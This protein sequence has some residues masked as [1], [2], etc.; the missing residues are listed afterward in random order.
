MIILFWKAGLLEQGFVPNRQTKKALE[1]HCTAHNYNRFC[2]NIAGLYWEHSKDL[3]CEKTVNTKRVTVSFTTLDVWQLTF[4][5][6]N[7]TFSFDLLLSKLSFPRSKHLKTVTPPHLLQ[8]PHTPLPDPRKRRSQPE[9]P[10]C[11]LTQEFTQK[12]VANNDCVCVWV[13]VSVLADYGLG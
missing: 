5:D 4:E 6:A 11:V 12:R 2:F 1:F 10:V 3:F 8:F 7:K 9:T 13:C